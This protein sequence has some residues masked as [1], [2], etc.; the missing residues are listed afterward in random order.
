MTDFLSPSPQGI[1]QAADILR[2]GDLVALPTETVYGLAGDAMQDDAVARIFEMKG[3]PAF[4]PLIAHVNGRDMAARYVDITPLADLLMQHFWPGPLTLVMN[5][6]PSGG[7]STLVTAG[8][9][10]LAVRMPRQE[11]TCK[12]ITALDRPVAA[13]SANPSGRLSPTKPEHV[14]RG[15]PAVT[16][17]MTGGKCDVGLESTIVDVTG[18]APVMLRAGAITYEDLQKLCGNVIDNTQQIQN[19]VP[20]APG[21]L[22]KHYAPRLPLRLNAVDVLPDEALLAFASYRFM[23][24]R[25][26]GRIQDLPSE[27]VL[28]L[29][30]TGDLHMAAANLFSMLHR[31]DQSD[32]RGIA[33]MNIP[34]AGIGRAIN[35]R[36]KRAAAGAGETA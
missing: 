18:D 25:G 5:L 33:V 6:K 15:L 22:L 17:I 31:L 23:G 30:D 28:N 16:A 8:L 13:P 27:R 26:G 10:T 29:S 11:T 36:L 34:D 9:R 4:N 32:A 3:R 14:A 20:S 21:Q 2:S 24:V 12:I 35:D 1:A 7:I 19:S